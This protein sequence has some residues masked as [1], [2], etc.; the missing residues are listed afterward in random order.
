M[1]CIFCKKESDND[2]SIEHIIPESLGN[3]DHILP[4]GIVCDKCNNFFARK[5]EKPLLE[6]PYFILSRNEE[7]I[8]N[9]KNRP[10]RIKAFFRDEKGEYFAS[11]IGLTP[12]NELIIHD[13][14]M[15]EQLKKMRRGELIFPKAPIE[16]PPG[17]M[18][19]F[20]AKAALEV[21]AHRLMKDPNSL[22]VIVVDQQF[23]PIRNF[24]RYGGASW[25]YHQRLLHHRD[26]PHLDPISNEYYQCLHEFDFL[27]TVDFELYF[28]LAIFGV[29]YVIN[30][31]E[32]SIDGYQKWLEEH[33]YI[34]PL[35]IE[36]K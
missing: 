36:K 12:D 11:E 25:I 8:L 17:I 21:L 15:I 31:G 5:V 14:G 16:P 22:N 30:M 4:K 24:A 2:K 28:V 1:N 34:S 10:A 29:E 9:K 33:D 19:R 18:D 32:P 13:E 35:Y 3:K 6:S 20:L 27:Y 26:F 23:D 7:F